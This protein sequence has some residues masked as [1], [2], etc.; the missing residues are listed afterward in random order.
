MLSAVAVRA[1]NL[2]VIKNPTSTSLQLC[3]NELGFDSHSIKGVYPEI[4]AAVQAA[5]NTSKNDTIYV[6]PGTYN[7]PVNV[8]SQMQILGADLALLQPTTQPAGTPNR[9]VPGTTIFPMLWIHD[10]MGGNV[11]ITNLTVDGSNFGSCSGNCQVAGILVQNAQAQL[12]SNTVQFVNVGGPG[13]GIAYFVQTGSTQVNGHQ[14][15]TQVQLQGNLAHDYQTVGYETNEVNTNVQLKN[16][17]AKGLGEMA[18]VTQTGFQVGFGAQAQ[19]QNNLASYHLGPV[20]PGGHCLNSS[21]SAN[22][23]LL[24]MP[25]PPGNSNPQVQQNV[26]ELAELGVAVVNGQGQVQNNVISDT[27]CDGAYILGDQVHFN[28]N[29]IYNTCNPAQGSCTTLTN[30]NAATNPSTAIYVVGGNQTDV[31]NNFVNFAPY[32]VASG[33]TNTNANNESLA[34]VVIQFA[35]SGFQQYQANP[36]PHDPA[37]AVFR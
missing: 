25:P 32:G 2:L 28:N 27:L 24:S 3:Y 9:A 15:Q 29:M 19:L 13:D 18:T 5:E 37:P 21:S 34:N 36:K 14:Q 33:G 11:Q 26:S 35:G 17:V 30:P 31:S 1:D 23:V 6:C 16:N 10:V 4:Q 22:Y 12:Q 8:Y 20:G 7:V